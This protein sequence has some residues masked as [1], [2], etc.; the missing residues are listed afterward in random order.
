MGSEYLKTVL[1]NRMVHGTNDEWKVFLFV[2][3]IE[4]DITSTNRAFEL[5]VHLC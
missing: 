2:E 4:A 5:K 1:A 3:E